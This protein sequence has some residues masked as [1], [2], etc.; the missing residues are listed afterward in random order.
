MILGA[1]EDEEDVRKWLMDEE[2]LKID[3][4]IEE[5]NKELL[6][7]LY[8]N[9]DDFVVLFYDEENDRDADEII[10]ALENIDDDLDVD[11]ISFV[12]C[13]GGEDVGVDYG[14]L[15]LPAFVFIQV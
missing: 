1:L 13:G 8:E 10:A 12:K 2:T 7:Y 9:I 4:T 3:G 5:V 15:D 6:A 11:N 14:I